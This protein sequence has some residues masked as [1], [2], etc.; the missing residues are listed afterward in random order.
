MKTLTTEERTRLEDFCWSQTT[1]APRNATLILLALSTGARASEVLGL[2]WKDLDLV[3]G[4]VFIKT[5]KRGKN[6]EI[7]LSR[8]LLELLKPMKSDDA[9]R[10][11]PISYQRLNQIWQ[12]WRPAKVPFHALRHTFALS[13]Y[14][15][16]KDINLVKHCLG[17]RSLTST[18]VY[19]D[20][21]YTIGS[22]KK[23]MGVR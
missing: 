15:R 4:S 18:T 22:L 12:D 2:T 9:S 7:P 6:R 8:R 10:L 20:E 1:L 16:R 11:F 23:S 19:L 5:L 3:A 14:H 17:H 21:A 13:L